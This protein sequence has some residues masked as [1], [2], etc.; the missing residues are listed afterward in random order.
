MNDFYRVLEVTP[1][2]HPEV[3]T[4]AYRALSKISN[5]KT[6][7]I[8]NAA[9]EVIGDNAKRHEYDKKRE[10]KDKIIGNYRIIKEIAEGGFGRTYLA[11]HK[12]LGTKVCI[13]HALHVSAQDTEFLMEEA[14]AMWDLRHFAIPNMRDV[15]TLDDGSIVLVMSY[16]E[17]PTLAQVIEKA[18]NLDPEHVAWIS[19]RCINGLRYLHYHGVVHGDV[20]PQNIIVQPNTHQAVLVDYGLSLVKPTKNTVNKGHTPFY[21]SP[22]QE[23]GET[24]IPESDFYSL[25]MT[26]IYALGGDVTARRVPSHTPDAMCAFIKRLLVRDALSRPNWQ[27]EDLQESFQIVREKSFG[28]KTSGMKPFPK[29]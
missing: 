28:R 5:E 24:L 27:K 8:L 11:E 22:E 1:K 15:V 25:G 14:K 26:M 20:K 4:A 3:I 9:Y 19:E 2:A 7:V 17:G 18:H 21:A 12:T 16:I 10:N 23:R 13:K 6:Q 29:L